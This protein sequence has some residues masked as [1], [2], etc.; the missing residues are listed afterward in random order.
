M[1]IEERMYTL[2]P[3]AMRSFLEMVENEGLAIQKGYLG[4]P[5]GYFTTETGE[6]NK[7]IHLW[8]FDSMGD[9]E[10]KRARLAQDS[11]WAAFVGKVLPLIVHME[12]RVLVPTPFSSIGGHK[13][14]ET[15][16]L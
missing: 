5:L 14:Q 7:V 2:H 6:L 9:R 12:N 10:L 15:N 11:R 3:G 8:Q 1:I 13:P 16:P 4:V